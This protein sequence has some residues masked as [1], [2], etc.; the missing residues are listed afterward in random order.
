MGERGFAIKADI[1][2]EAW[3]RDEFPMVCESCLGDNPYVRM[4][5]E[6]YGAA[7]KVCQRPYTVFRWK[8][9]RKAKSKR[10]EICQT[11]A[12]MKNICQTCLL[13][14]QYGLPV[15]VR[16]AF[17]SGDGTTTTMSD[18][19][20]EWAS[21]KHT[22]EL[23]TNGYGKVANARSLAKVARSEPYYKKQ[24]KAHVCVQYARGECQKGDE[25]PY[26]HTIATRDDDPVNKRDK[27]VVDPVAA[28]LS[29]DQDQNAAAEEEKTTL[30][31]T[32]IVEEEEKKKHS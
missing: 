13:D 2:K 8:P 29:E 16:D 7:C 5:K 17:L 28:K 1:H 10:T 15:E 19:N 32:S 25:C 30:V 18:P 14:L 11:C 23:E 21:Q 31:T 12:R 20:R 3:E 9:G 4:M 24:T 26:I 27:H 22:R 6:T